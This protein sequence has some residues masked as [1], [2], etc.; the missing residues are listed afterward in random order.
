MV[1]HWSLSDSKSPN[2]SRNFPSIL[3]DL[4][5][6]LVWMIATCSLHFQVLDSLY[7]SLGDGFRVNLLQLVSPSSSCSI[8]FS[9]L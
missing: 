1:F 8:A 3:A 2:I 5:N 7:H 6:A 9:P 4:N